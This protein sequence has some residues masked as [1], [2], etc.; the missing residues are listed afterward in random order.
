MLK[1]QHYKS[2]WTHKTWEKHLQFIRVYWKK[3][4]KRRFYPVFKWLE[5]FQQ[6][7]QRNLISERESLMWADHMS[8]GKLLSGH[9]LHLCHIIC[10]PLRKAT[11]YALGGTAG[12]NC[13]T[14][15]CFS[16]SALFWFILSK[17]ML[18]DVAA[19]RCL[20][21]SGKSSAWMLLLRN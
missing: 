11:A 20:W 15:K 8:P 10:Q 5:G 7:L 3:E 21:P 12:D 16:A 18:L 1:Y 19:E 17:Q 2:E 13:I 9:Y 4:K 6:L 14:S